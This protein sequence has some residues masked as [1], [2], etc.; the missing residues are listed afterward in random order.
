MNAKNYLCQAY[1]LDQ[2]IKIVQEDIEQLQDLATSVSSPGFE[3]HYNA[4]RNSEAPFVHT[5]C[6]MMEKQD[7][8]NHKLHLMMKL[9]CE[10][11]DVLEDLENKDE[12]LVLTYRYLRNWTWDRIGKELSADERTIR[13]WHYQALSHLV[14]P[15][16]PTICK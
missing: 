9:K 7:D 8:L 12:R 6:K 4:T 5:L 2:R 3:E 15:E 11:S 13:R 14:V 1:R 16:N 10:I